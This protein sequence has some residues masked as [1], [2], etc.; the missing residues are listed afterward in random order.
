M[1]NRWRMLTFDRFMRRRRFLD[2]LLF[3]S[4]S[5]SLSFLVVSFHW[6]EKG[7]FY[8]ELYHGSQLP[9]C[10]SSERKRCINP[11]RNLSNAAGR[12]QSQGTQT[13]ST[14]SRCF[15]SNTHD[16]LKA[17]TRRLG[18]NNDT[19]V[20]GMEAVFES[21]LNVESLLLNKVHS[22]SLLQQ[23]LCH[24][25]SRVLTMDA[26]EEDYTN[27][28]IATIQAWTF[29]LIYWATHINQHLPA[30]PEAKLRV[31]Q[32]QLCQTEME[33]RQIGIFDF[34]C[35]DAKF[36]VVS[37]GKLGLGAG[38]RL[39]AVNA[40]VAGIASNRTV[41]FLNS[42]PVGPKTL[43]EPWPLASCS[44]RDMQCFYMPITPCTLTY[45]DIEHA[46]VLGKEHTRR[47][48]QLGELGS[49]VNEKRV[50]VM[51]HAL[52]PQRTPPTLRQNL[53]SI[54]KLHILR[55]LQE[56]RPDDPLLGLL[57]EAT[58]QVLADA[59]TYNTYPYYGKAS[60]V[61]HAFVMFMMRPNRYYA[62]KLN[63][64][65]RQTIPED[66]DPKMA[67]GLPIRASDKCNTESECLK[68]GQYM[69][70]ME[71]TWEDRRPLFLGSEH[72]VLV[73]K[74]SSESKTKPSIIVTS[75]SW[76]VHQEQQ[77]YLQEGLAREDSFPFQFLNNKFD[78]HQSTGNP[79]KMMRLGMTNGTLDDIMLSSVSS[80]KLQLYSRHSVGNCC[81]NF[82]LLLFDFLEEGCGPAKDQ[83][84]ECLQDNGNS[85]YRLCC[86][87]SKTEECLKKKNTTNS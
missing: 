65:I 51:N 17:G 43:R 84:V 9:S 31:T 25:K 68:F 29:R 14:Q 28:S 24:D 69:T 73:S 37:L 57:G 70:L 85:E 87:W 4:L 8:E 40:L 52:R 15:P 35:P 78:L 47:L 75:E 38:M 60:N 64:I 59:P 18:N 61:N 16:W 20:M 62:K 50:L 22:R 3:L 41:V 79:K 83:N 53:V 5:V 81:S 33:L 46:T 36:L 12:N 1:D 23:T 76:A 44:R 80:L 10:S 66:F 48:F 55:P 6:V 71:Q 49:D 7:K 26:P 56:K 34:E 27:P 19:S 2:V 58:N 13:G 54:I 86:L 45:S 67:L 30:V 74:N 63:S 82:H 42:A 32:S 72:E 11:T 21:I 39:G 77:R